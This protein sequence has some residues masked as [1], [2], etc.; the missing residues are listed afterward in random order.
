MRPVEPCG[1]LVPEIKALIVPVEINF[2][3]KPTKS[4]KEVGISIDF[5]LI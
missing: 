1:V 4:P 5:I 2:H 3:L